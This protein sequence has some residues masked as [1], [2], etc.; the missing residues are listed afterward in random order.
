MLFGVLKNQ[1]SLP[2][3]EDHRVLIQKKNHKFVHQK[4]KT[5]KPK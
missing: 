5:N 1:G 2:S 3:F 4:T